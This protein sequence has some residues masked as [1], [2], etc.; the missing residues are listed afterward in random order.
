VGHTLVLHNK[1]M[2]VRESVKKKVFFFKEKKSV[3]N[4]PLKIF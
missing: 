4:T 1:I 3:F 2:S